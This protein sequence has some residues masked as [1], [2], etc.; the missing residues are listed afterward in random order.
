MLTYNGKADV[1]EC[2]A[3]LSRSTYPNLEMVVV[4]NGSSD[5]S[6]AA[7]EAGFPAVRIIENGRNLRWAGG[8]NVGIRY[9]LESGADTIL[10]LNNDT[11]MDPEMVT[12][13]VGA[14]QSDPEV[15]IL[16]PKIYYH[17]QPETVW[18]AGG[19]VN[20]WWGAVRHVGIRQRDT[21]QFDQVV[22]VDYVTGCALMVKREVVEKIGLIDTVYTAYGED[23]DYCLRATRV[24]Y[25]LLMVPSAVMWHKV[26]AFWGVASPRKIWMK[27][28]SHIILFR[29]YAPPLA[30]FTTIPLYF[31]WDG[32]R[33]L[34]LIL[35]GRI[36][37]RS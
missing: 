7:I 33:V 1:L 31:V 29:R 15:G 9:A 11:T 19:K 3:S 26:G 8:N 28:R 22:A 23:T 36:R 2:L 24:G 12:Q 6:V 20:L 37:P 35:T 4:D 17:A 10:L 13:L 30:W 21:G 34:A 16:G 18:Y 5:G 27:L 25:R 14:A 32:L